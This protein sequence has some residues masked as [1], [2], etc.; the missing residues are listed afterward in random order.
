[1]S[2]NAKLIILM[3]AVPCAVVGLFVIDFKIWRLKHPEAPA[4]TWV[5]EK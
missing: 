3:I 5:L 1:M 4:W 2:H